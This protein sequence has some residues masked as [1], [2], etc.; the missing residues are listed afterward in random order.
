MTDDRRGRD[1]VLIG[2]GP[3]SSLDRTLE[4]ISKPLGPRCT[5]LEADTVVGNLPVAPLPLRFCALASASMN[6]PRFPRRVSRGAL[7]RGGD[8]SGDGAVTVEVREETYAI[9]IAVPGLQVRNGLTRGKREF[10]VGGVG[11]PGQI[12]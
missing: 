9:D 3:P 1:A 10:F 11:Q 12:G 7:A 6:A 2:H 4:R 5:S 8:S